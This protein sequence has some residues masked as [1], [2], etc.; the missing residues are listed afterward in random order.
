MGDHENDKLIADAL[1]ALASKM[2]RDGL[3][4]FHDPLMPIVHAALRLSDAIT[5][6]LLAYWLDSDLRLL[7]V[8]EIAKGARD[9]ALFS[10][11]FL[12]RRALA[13]G[14][15]SCVLIHNHPTGE[16]GRSDAD[17]EAAGRIDRQ[18]AAIGILVNAHVVVTWRG[19][20]DIR[21]GAVTLF[22][23]LLPEAGKMPKA[24]SP[25]C[26]HCNGSL[27]VSA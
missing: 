2:A 18:L 19:F 4:R 15:D 27:E 5:E 26:P 6:T 23:N 13:S 14:A 24:D 20:C 22:K 16:T 21:T 17:V 25:R 9:Q 7:G 10:R 3:P 1:A 8:E 11:D 12:A